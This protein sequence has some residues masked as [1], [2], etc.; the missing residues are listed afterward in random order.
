[1][2]RLVGNKQ[3]KTMRKT[4][5][6]AFISIMLFSS[7]CLAVEFI[8]KK[9]NGTYVYKCEANFGGKVIVKF[10]KGKVFVDGGETNG[11]DWSIIEGKPGRKFADLVA[12]DACGEM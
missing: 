1:L 12:K 8:M 4:I 6:L 7:N 10:K 2:D 3:E 9:S 11:E 5:V